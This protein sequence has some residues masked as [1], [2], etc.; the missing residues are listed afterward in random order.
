M[1][2]SASLKSDRANLSSLF[3]VT[4]SLSLLI[5]ALALTAHAFPPALPHTIYG[6]ARDEYGNPLG[7][8]ATIVLTTST[9]VILKATVDTDLEPGVNYRL[10]VPLDAGVRTDAY[11]G[12]AVNSTVP[13]RIKVSLNNTLLLPIEMS[14]DYSLMGQPGKQ[15]RIDLTLGED[16]NGNGLPDAW[17]LAMI[18]ARGWNLTLANLRTNN[19]PG[20]GGVSLMQEYIAGTYAFEDDTGLN[21]KIARFDNGA[22]VIEFMAVRGRTYTI[23][24]SADLKTWSTVSFKAD[25]TDPNT[26]LV[27]AQTVDN[28]ESTTVKLMQVTVPAPASGPQP[29]FFKLRIQ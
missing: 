15:T 29:L 23:V 27:Q 3:S 8:N 25:M 7:T 28:Y 1:N 17:E 26:G 13:F 6:M 24:G 21:I 10:T 2:T 9:G 22:P 4:W 14:G 11:R 19:M 20:G 12:D 16:T 5:L 18:S